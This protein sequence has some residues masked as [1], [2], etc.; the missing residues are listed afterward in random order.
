MRMHRIKVFGRCKS[1]RLYS[2]DCNH[3]VELVSVC[4]S[5]LGWAFGVA[6]LHRAGT[7][8]SNTTCSPPTIYSRS[9]R[10]AIVANSI[11]EQRAWMR[12]WNR[13]DPVSP[14]IRFHAPSHLLILE[15]GTRRACT[16]ALF[17]IR[18]GYGKADVG[19][20]QFA[21]I[22]LGDPKKGLRDRMRTTLRVRDLHLGHRDKVAALALLRQLQ[23]FG[24]GV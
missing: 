20:R 5:F 24:H 18:R 11:T 12:A 21:S 8:V 22:A 4:R 10:P 14:R 3:V 7:C 6:Y 13:L 16:A 1:I 9:V 23:T 19:Q 15:N 2:S 17:R